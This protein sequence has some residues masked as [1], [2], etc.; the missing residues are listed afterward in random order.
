MVTF[1]INIP[2]MLAY[3][4]QHHGSYGFGDGVFPTIYGNVRD[5]GPVYEQTALPQVRDLLK[6][7]GF[8]IN[9]PTQQM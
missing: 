3:I 7:D 2:Q 5:G 8:G 1:T 6:E 4:Y 9:Q